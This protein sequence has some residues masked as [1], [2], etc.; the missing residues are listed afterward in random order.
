[1]LSYKLDKPITQLKV[2]V[3]TPTYNRD[4]LLAR[5]YQYFKAQKNPF[6]EVRWFVLDDS[7][8]RSKNDFFSHDAAIE[9]QW[10]EQRIAL[11][12]KRNR[13]NETALAW[14]AD[15]ICCMDDDDWYG[16]DYIFDMSTLLLQSDA[17]FAGSGDDYYFDVS[18][19]RVLFVPAVR[20][21]TSCN[22]V[23][24]YKSFVLQSRRYDSAAKS[25]EEPAFIQ[26]DKILQHPDIKRVHL[27]MA[28]QHN[29]VSKRGYM[30]D[31]RRWT[32]LTLDDF[33]M[34]ENDRLFYKH[35]FYSM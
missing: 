24:C 17:C 33:P 8:Q 27:A 30:K 10:V 19:Q 6:D 21:S 34:H 31:A 22:A 13:L 15:I 28:Y 4:H 26:R 14:D 2:A 16:Q 9:Y 20:E 11:G 25:G 18:A 3:V 32:D 35:D 7:P 29:T 12:E 1:M 23:L 5:S